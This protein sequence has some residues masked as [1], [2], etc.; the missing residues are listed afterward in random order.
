MKKVDIFSFSI[1]LILNLLLLLL[2]FTSRTPQVAGKIRV[3]LVADGKKNV[4]Y[5]GKKEV[6]KKELPEPKQPDLPPTVP[7]PEPV[8]E[9]KKLDLSNLQQQIAA[10]V[11]SNAA[12]RKAVVAEKITSSPQQSQSVKDAL[13]APIKTLGISSGVPSGYKLGALDGDIEAKWNPSNR[14]PEYPQSAQLK[15]I[16]GTV[17]LLLNIDASGNIRNVAFQRKSGYPE[18]DLA[19]EKIARTWKINLSKNGK[20]VQGDVVLEYNFKLVGN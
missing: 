19:I 2:L 3:G 7:T 1:S 8:P 16:N 13:E 5:E 9:V 10:P 17:S 18:I 6:E 15:G 11:L 4:S 12:G 14:N 20:T